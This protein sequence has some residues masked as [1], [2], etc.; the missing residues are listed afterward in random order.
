MPQDHNADDI[1]IGHGQYDGI[2][3]YPGRSTASKVILNF[4]INLFMHLRCNNVH[5]VYKKGILHQDYSQPP[6][7]LVT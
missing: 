3:V 5:I 4:T 7:L 2:E 1:P 6:K